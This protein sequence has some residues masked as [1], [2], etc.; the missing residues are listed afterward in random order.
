MGPGT[1]RLAGSSSRRQIEMCC[2]VKTV[3]ECTRK[4][5]LVAS[6]VHSNFRPSIGG[7]NNRTSATAK[8]A[9]E[10][11]YREGSQK[12][13]NGRSG[14]ENMRSPSAETS[15]GGTLAKGPLAVCVMVAP[16]GAS[17]PPLPDHVQLF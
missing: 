10:R 6:A 9:K 15:H 3:S 7:Q 1:D 16:I 17:A 14:L 5:R 2:N 4:A 8:I 12:M 13:I 11:H